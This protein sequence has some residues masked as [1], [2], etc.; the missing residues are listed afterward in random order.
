MQAVTSSTALINERSSAMATG[1]PPVLVEEELSVVD[2]ESFEGQ[3]ASELT[4]RKF[5]PSGPDC[6]EILPVSAFSD[7]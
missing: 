7:T 6:N 2:C 5:P 1:E 4:S 3:M